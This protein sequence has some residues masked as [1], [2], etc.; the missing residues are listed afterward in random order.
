MN[1]KLITI[2]ALLFFSQTILA[3]ITVKVDR[4]P[5][6]V[7]ESFHIIYESNEKLDAKP[8]FRPLQNSFTVLDSRH[9]SNT[10]I[11]N[12]KINYSQMWI[13]TVIADKAGR[14]TIPSIRFGNET[15]KISA[16]DVVAAS[17]SEEGNSSDDVFIDIEVNTKTPYVQAQLIYTLKLYRSVVTSNASLSEPEVVGGQAVINKLGEDSSYETVRNGKRYAVIQRQYVIF[18][19]SSGSLKIEP[20]VFQGQTGGSSNFFSFD[21]F[22]SQSKSILKRSESVELDVKPIPDTFTGDTWLPAEKLTINE[23]WS[24]EP[25]NLKQGE[26]TTRTLTLAAHGLAASH[27]PIIE[28][29]LPSELKLYPDQP[30][31]EETNDT[32]GYIG[33]RQDKM[34]IIPTKAG[35]YTLPAIKIP[36]WNTSTDKMEIAELPERL[37]QVEASVTAQATLP[38]QE[39]VETNK[40][41]T[42][43]P[44]RQAQS[45]FGVTQTSNEA[46][47]WKWLS[48]VLLILWLLTIILF[49]KSRRPALSSAKKEEQ[50]T[51]SRQYIKKIQQACKNNDAIKAKQALLEWAKHH[52][53]DKYVNSLTAIKEYSNDAFQKQLDELNSNLYGNHETNKW[54]GSAFLKSFESQSFDPKEIKNSSGNL[55][56]LYKT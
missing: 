52:W 37:I 36:W 32:K 18:P 28:N 23:Q 35:D 6:V 44:D 1:Y 7:D 56:P 8:D 13:I 15:T 25:S 47:I 34:A 4:E 14:I 16:I 33:V 54:Q 48:L 42:L 2:L 12:G 51:S 38:V 9:R 41:I 26:A 39:R 50:K 40:D 31:F 17:Q 5:I 55:E 27:L 29:N 46:P 3:E 19:Q 30:Q 10:N 11:T 21:P 20:I 24:V 22:R 53:P 49:W 45:K 43:T